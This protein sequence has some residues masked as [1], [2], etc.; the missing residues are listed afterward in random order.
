MRQYGLKLN[1]G[2]CVF[3]I[4]VGRFLGYVVIEQGIEVNPE[5]VQALRSMTPLATSKKLND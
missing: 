3:D 4:K 5:K 2:K 1:P